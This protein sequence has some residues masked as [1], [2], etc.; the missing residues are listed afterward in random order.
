LGD[1]TYI[2]TFS[3]AFGAWTLRIWSQEYQLPLIDF[4]CSF[5]NGRFVRSLGREGVDIG[6]LYEPFGLALDSAKQLLF[7]ADK[8]NHRVQCWNTRDGECVLNIDAYQLNRPLTEDEV[9]EIYDQ[10]MKVYYAH[11]EEFEKHQQQQ[12]QLPLH[13]QNNTLSA[14]VE[15]VIL[16]PAQTVP[17]QKIIMTQPHSVCMDDERKRLFI[18]DTFN[19][20][21]LVISLPDG[22]FIREIGEEGSGKGEF[23]YPGG[24]AYWQNKIFVSDSNHSVQVQKKFNV[25]FFRLLHNDTELITG[26][27]C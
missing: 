5:P 15:P 22:R 13:L 4:E 9:K 26:V 1:G 27:Q 10:Q 7:V 24:V 14:P 17:P 23:K 25:F 12:L 3:A 19:H 16:D 8:E 6:E 21:I 2:V 20:R 11:L 18:A